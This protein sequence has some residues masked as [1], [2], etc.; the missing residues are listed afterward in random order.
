LSAFEARKDPGGLGGRTGE[1]AEMPDLVSPAYDGVPA[2]DPPGVH[3]RHRGER[4]RVQ[5]EHR[6]SPKCVSLMKKTVIGYAQK[7]F[8]GLDGTPD[9][10]QRIYRVMAGGGGGGGRA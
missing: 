2:P 6:W 1:I 8:R 3:R 9:S 4:A 10:K 7:D 5:I